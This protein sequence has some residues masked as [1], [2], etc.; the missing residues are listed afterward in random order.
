MS[1][2]FEGVVG[3]IV[4]D[5][6][7]DE[8]ELHDE[9]LDVEKQIKDE[10]VRDEMEHIME[11]TLMVEHVENETAKH[12]DSF[13][14]EV[15]HNSEIFA[16]T[17][18]SK[19]KEQFEEAARDK[20]MTDT[21]DHQE[22]DELEIDDQVAELTDLEKEA[23]KHHESAQVIKEIHDLEVD[24]ESIEH[25]QDALVDDI[26]DSLEFL[27]STGAN[28]IESLSLEEAIAEDKDVL[29]EQ[30]QQMQNLKD[31]YGDLTDKGEKSEV[32]S[33]FNEERKLAGQEQVIITKEE[34]LDKLEDTVNKGGGSKQQVYKDEQEIEKL[35]E[36]LAVDDATEI[37]HEDVT[38]DKLEDAHPNNDKLLEDI[39]DVDHDGQ[40]LEFDMEMAIS[41]EDVLFVDDV[42]A[43]KTGG[44][45]G[46]ELGTPGEQAFK[47]EHKFEEDQ[48]D[49][50]QR[51]GVEEIVEAEVKKPC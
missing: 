51:H 15:D 40:N 2:D 42:S 48:E 20:M 34:A 23:T 47:A 7:L 18:D 21:L 33:E 22:K 13:S 5:I 24:A 1:E 37:L 30:K 49:L 19:V 9:E 25:K 28:D 4:D 50:I 46:G 35:S 16:N 17:G 29:R 27:D 14:E 6:S 12:L 32:A 45:V 36:E 38:M 31:V 8:G 44:K 10:E 11:D 43:L 3:D 39:E 41:D 26:E